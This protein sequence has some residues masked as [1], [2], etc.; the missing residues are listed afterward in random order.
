MA[1]TEYLRLFAQFFIFYVH[2]ADFGGRFIH[3][4]LPPHLHF[5]HHQFA[6]AFRVEFDE[7]LVARVAG[8]ALPRA[9]RAEPPAPSSQAVGDNW[10]RMGRTAVL[11]LPSVLI[12]A[13][14]NYLLNPAHCDFA[15][16]V[17]ARPVPFAFDPRLVG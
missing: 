14:R 3:K 10:A 5:L 16:I 7:A 15:K 2:T 11:E 6:F 12:P 4:T 17:I 13:E 9:W 1:D 8:R